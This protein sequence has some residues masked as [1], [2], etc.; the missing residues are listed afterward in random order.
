MHRSRKKTVLITGCS[1]GIGLCTAKELKARGYRVFA[2]A[3]KTEDLVTLQTLGFEVER[4]DLSDTSSIDQALT[5]I[6]KK[7]DHLDALVNNAGYLVVGAVEDLPLEVIKAQFETNFFG[8]IYLTSKVI[9]IMRKQDEGRIVFI[10]SINGLIAVPYAGAY[11]ASKFALEGLVESLAME[12]HQSHLHVSLIQPGFIATDLR[13]TISSIP[14]RENSYYQDKYDSFLALNK[15][16]LKDGE[17]LPF[18]QLPEAVVKKIIHALE[19]K[20]P[21]LRYRVT[22]FAHFL[23]VIKNVLPNQMQIKIMSKLCS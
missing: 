9:P 18:I 21:K 14:N 10:S 8:T 1:R 20:H 5:N 11:C 22:L 3:R 4:L 13:K 17:K 2:T 19:A 6:C 15:Y 7:T 16:S 12:L 23:N